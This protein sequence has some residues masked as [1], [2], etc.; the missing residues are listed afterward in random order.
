MKSIKINCRITFWLWIVTY[1][2]MCVALNVSMEDKT[3]TILLGDTYIG[4]AKPEYALLIA[5]LI[6]VWFL[7]LAVVTYSNSRTTNRVIRFISHG[8]I[9]WLSLSLLVCF[10]IFIFA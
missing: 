4:I 6:A 9:V 7:P 1:A 2:I 8:I 10:L 5:V 3:H